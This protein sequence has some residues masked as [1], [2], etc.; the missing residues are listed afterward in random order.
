MISQLTTR[1]SERDAL[2]AQITAQLQQDPRIVAAWAHGSIGRGETDDFSDI[3]LFVVVADAHLETVMA[4]RQAF[5]A[6]LPGL[7]Y[8]A[9]APQNRPPGGA[10]LGTAY[11]GADG[12]HQVD[13]YWQRQSAAAIPPRVRLLFDRVNLPPT[14]TPL[15]WDYQPV[16]DETPEAQA[17]R[18]VSL[19]WLMLLVTAKYAA[20]TPNE[21]QMGLWRFALVSRDDVREFLNLPPSVRW[22]DLP[23]HPA[24]AD[25]LR[26]LREGIAEMETLMAQLEKRGLP[27]PWPIVPSAR[28]FITFV[29]AMCHDKLPRE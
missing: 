25:K 13:W 14:E 27:M 19:F 8:A 5:A 1:R 2:L 17:T 21:D 4:E 15:W 23:P 9:E 16:P 6:S 3:D 10:Y 26:I 7:L 11:D 22:E 20:R 12:P 18:R 28:R 29:E 24:P